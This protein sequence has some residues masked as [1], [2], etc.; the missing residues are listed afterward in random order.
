VCRDW[1]KETACRHAKSLGNCRTSQKYRANC[2]KTCE[3]C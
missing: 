2:A 3:L 1:F